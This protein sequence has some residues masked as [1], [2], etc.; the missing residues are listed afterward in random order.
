MKKK[1]LFFGYTLDVGG[2]EKVM[3][4]LV[5]V[6]KKDYDIDI[7]L[8]KAQG[9]FLGAVPEGVNIIELRKDVFSYTLFRYV[10]FF[11]K[12][13]INKLANSKDYYA[14]IGFIEGR[15]ATWV[16]DIKKNIRK[17]A[18]IHTD[19][20]LFD[21]GIS[22]EEAVDSYSKMDKVVFV[23]ETSKDN[24]IQKYGVANDTAEV[25]HNLIDE[26]R[27]IELS[28]ISVTSNDKFTFVNVGRMSP[29]KRQDRLVKAAKLLKDDGLNFK[30]QIVGAGS[31]ESAIK[32]MI[33]E[34]GVSDCVDLLGLQTNPYPYVRQA[35]CFV[36]SSD[37]E[38]YCVAVKESLLLGTPVI[39]TNVSGIKEELCD[40]KY[41]IICDVNT[42]SLYKAMKSVLL[43]DSILDN[44]RKD[45]QNYDCANGVILEK[46]YAI[47][48]RN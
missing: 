11:R 26:E 39:A 41:G 36:L 38:G 6:L 48:E 27:I 32:A 46:L 16:A 43:S 44:F 7:A 13:K 24:F 19:V 1:L 34:Y 3:V 9:D 2:A 23:A 35:D 29:P 31:E 15:S 21:I 25:L 40:G 10:P 30:I 42:N 14:A 37:I 8:L 22:K 20:N 12:R 5:N 47:I 18:W 17:I 33:S 4:D 28:K 45:L